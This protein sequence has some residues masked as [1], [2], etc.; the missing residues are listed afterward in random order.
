MPRDAFI[1]NDIQA[2]II[3]SAAAATRASTFEAQKSRKSRAA[4]LDLHNEIMFH[5]S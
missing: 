4:C 5:F 1:K 3:N 2:I